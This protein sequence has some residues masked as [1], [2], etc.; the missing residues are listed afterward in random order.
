MHD[1]AFLREQVK[2]LKAELSLKNRIE[3]IKRGLYGDKKGSQLL[4]EGF[5]QSATKTNYNLNVEI[6]KDGSGRVVPPA[7]NAPPATPPA[8]K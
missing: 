2:S 7:T 6:K 8:P 4:N 5:K 3:W 1:L